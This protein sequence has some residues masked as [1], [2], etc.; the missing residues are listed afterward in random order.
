ME[1][2][3][4]EVSEIKIDNELFKD[5]LELKSDNH[6]PDLVRCMEFY[7]RTN[8]NL[9]YDIKK[10]NISF[11][12]IVKILDYLNLGYI[13]KFSKKKQEEEG[14]Y[15]IEF[16][17]INKFENSIDLLSKINKNINDSLSFV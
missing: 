14:N 11:K 16:S 2:Y 7:R 10:L 12:R 6:Y 4:C 8:L 9:Y 3:Y 1:R 17:K 13:V 15:E 5:E